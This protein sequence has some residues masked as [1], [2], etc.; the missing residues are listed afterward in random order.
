MLWVKKCFTCSSSIV[1][2]QIRVLVQCDRHVSRQSA[3]DPGS[4]VPSSL[5]TLKTHDIV[6]HETPPPPPKKTNKKLLYRV[7]NW[8]DR[9]TLC[10]TPQSRKFPTESFPVRNSS[11]RGTSCLPE[12]N[13]T[14]Q[15]L[16][17]YTVYTVHSIFRKDHISGYRNNVTSTVVWFYLVDFCH[18]I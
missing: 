13:R 9:P 1:P 8:D 12:K 16:L 15:S 14:I 5:F 10:S 6:R 7:T 11:P 4:F 3:S 2:H 17:P 18:F